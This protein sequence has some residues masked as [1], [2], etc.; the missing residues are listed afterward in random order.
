MSSADVISQLTS[1]IGAA[2]RV[3][4]AA[5]KLS[6]GGLR[7]FCMASIRTASSLLV[8]SLIVFFASSIA[9]SFALFADAAFSGF[10][11]GSFDGGLFPVRSTIHNKY[12]IGETDNASVRIV[13]K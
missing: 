4:L 7:S 13:G 6:S 12:S 5:S 3:A 1:P 9:A 11:G 10:F 8:T 2:L